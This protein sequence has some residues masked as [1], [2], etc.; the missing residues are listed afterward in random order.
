MKYFVLKTS[1]I[2]SFLTPWY[3]RTFRAGARRISRERE[4]TGKRPANEYIVINTDE[5]FAGEV[6][7]ILRRFGVEV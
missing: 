7:K 1:D 5:P 3:Q 2:E 6:V 4:K